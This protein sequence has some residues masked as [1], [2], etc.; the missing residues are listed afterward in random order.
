MNDRIP[1]LEMLIGAQVSFEEKKAKR[2]GKKSS[3][4]VDGGDGAIATFEFDAKG[5][6]ISVDIDTDAY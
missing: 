3:I 6:L 1:F 2:T 5:M 4:V